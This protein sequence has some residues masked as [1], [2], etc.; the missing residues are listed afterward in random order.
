MGPVFSCASFLPD[1][2]QSKRQR[3]SP[4]MPTDTDIRRLRRFNR[5]VT[6]ALGA[7][8]QS[9]LGRGRPLGVA[10]VIQA[11][12]QGMTEVRE[13]RAYLG[14]DSGFMSRNLRT[15][16]EDGLISTEASPEDARQ[17]QVHLT[18]AGQAEFQAYESLSDQ[19]ALE[20][21]GRSRHREDLLAALDLISATFNQ[22]KP[23][24]HAVDPSHA[25]VAY[26]MREYT[27]ELSRRFGRTFAVTEMSEAERQDFLPPKGVF[28][29]ASLDGVAV[30]CG[31]LRPLGDK[32]G[33][34]KRVWINPAWRG[35]GLSRQLMQALETE[36][37][38]LGFDR[39]RLDTSRHLGEAVALYH[40][41]GYREIDRYNDNPDA[42]HFFEKLL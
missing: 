30:G 21:L 20:I 12:G 35:R 6:S 27:Q 5:S 10:R 39:L 40:A 4:I 33:E 37:R 16:E 17:R 38:G 32:I 23:H 14:L 7:M 2:S 13:L 24:I 26:A 9:F 15:L 11:I 31:A 19:H 25:D 29:L 28:L 41:L 22:A 1:L 42:D 34:V 36:A 18:E 3:E 8:D